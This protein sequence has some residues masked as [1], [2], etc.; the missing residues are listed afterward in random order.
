MIA[1][2]PTVNRRPADDEMA[3][4]I[5]IVFVG[6]VWGALIGGLIAEDKAECIAIFATC[7]LASL[8]ALAVRAIARTRTAR[9]NNQLRP[10][11]IGRRTRRHRAAPHA[12]A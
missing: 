9:T 4:G 12:N 5:C 11:R 8:A 7:V 3:V 10:A 6:V 1:P 2:Q